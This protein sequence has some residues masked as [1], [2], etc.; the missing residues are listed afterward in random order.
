MPE[1]NLL[2]PAGTPLTNALLDSYTS[3]LM[4]AGAQHAGYSMPGFYNTP[5]HPAEEQAFRAWLQKNKVPFDPDVAM[6]DYDMRGFWKGLM[7]GDPN[8]VTGMNPNDKQLHFGDYYKTPYHKSFS[9]ESKYAKQT[10]PRWNNLD[11]LVM[12]DG[13][14]LVDERKEAA[15][16]WV[17]KYSRHDK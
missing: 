10:G 11:Q 2:A 4:Q 16:A 13:T 15:R 8:A 17:Q 9:A 14:V 1:Q 3:S 12:P 6:S 5:L 7:S